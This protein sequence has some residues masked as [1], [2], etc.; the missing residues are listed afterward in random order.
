MRCWW[1]VV[2][3]TL[4]IIYQDQVL[5]PTLGTLVHAVCATAGYLNNRYVHANPHNIIN[6][7]R[8]LAEQPNGENGCRAWEKPLPVSA[9]LALPRGNTRHFCRLAMMTIGQESPICSILCASEQISLVASGSPSMCPL[10]THQG[11]GSWTS[12]K[13][14]YCIVGV[15]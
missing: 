2:A 14:A 8:M 9:S 5:R 1:V 15:G 13:R 11:E 12:W 4:R 10:R 3:E 6:G 7:S